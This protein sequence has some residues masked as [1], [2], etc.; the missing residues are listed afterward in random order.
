M[1]ASA[2]LPAIL[3]PDLADRLPDIQREYQ[4]NGKVF[5][6][7]YLRADLADAL[8]RCIDKHI[9]WSLVVS[10]R[11][12]DKLVPPEE[13]G[14]MSKKQRLAQLPPKPKSVMDYVFAYERFDIGLDLFTSKYPWSEPLHELYEGFRQPAY[15]AL[16]QAITGN[17]QGRKVS[18][19]L[20]RYRSGHY[21][22]PHYDTDNDVSTLAA[23]VLGLTPVW[24]KEWGGLLTFCD[25]NGKASEYRIPSFN[26]LAL[27]HVPQWHYVS[28]VK[29]SVVRTRNSIFGWY[30][31]TPS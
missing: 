22:T 30:F 15:I 16:M 1:S 23:H 11:N 7:D 26:T 10:T 6:K 18:M 12:G 20:S 2:E 19:Q 24:K 13:Y 27:F 5:V 3:N 25:E 29:S 31:S 28:P 9:E 4:A 8:Y 14:L 21:L 17:K